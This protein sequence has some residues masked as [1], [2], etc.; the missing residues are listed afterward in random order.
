MIQKQ[1]VTLGILSAV[2]SLT[3]VQAGGYMVQETNHL[4][5]QAFAG[6]AAAVGDISTMYVNPAS[7]SYINDT[8]AA[9]HVAAILPHS[10]FKIGPGTRHT[11][12][13]GT[14]FAT[15]SNG[16]NGGVAGVLPS[17]YV[18]TKLDEKVRLGLGVAVP[19]G[20]A[21]KY[22]EGW[23]GR[24]F[25]IKSQ[26]ETINVN[27]AIAV[28]LSDAF[29][30]G[31]GMSIQHT[32]VHLSNMARLAL[33]NFDTKLDFKGKDTGYG[34]NLGFLYEPWKGTRFGVAY[35]SHVRHVL[36]GD[37]KVTNPGFFLANAQ[38]A[39]L[40]RN[41]PIEAKMKTPDV[42]NFSA[43]HDLNEKWTVLGDVM[44]TRWTVFRELKIN[45]RDVDRSYTPAPQGWQN[46]FMYSLGLNYKP[47]EKWVFRAGVAYDESPTR[48][49]HRSPRLPDQ[50]RI[51]L[52]AGADYKWSDY[53]TTRLSYTYITARKAKVDLFAP[54]ANP[55][56]VTSRIQGKYTN[57]VNII[58]LQMNVK[59]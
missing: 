37:V 38:L 49:E 28:K 51:W 9:A 39:P 2:G 20:L 32:K 35:R 15:G 27:P 18:M 41:G 3:A 47:T 45:R 43:S 54:G 10:K 36:K 5:S 4:Y 11:A 50:D 14:V 52:A 26:I 22:P 44:M 19:F 29:S 1:R 21:T 30:V 25:A 58:G 6:R 42:V 12:G 56:L 24:Y 46:V 53:I 33:N 40:F 23:A 34:F 55:A 17:L 8:V 16:G 59:F 57:H 13:G 7:M 48:N 31:V